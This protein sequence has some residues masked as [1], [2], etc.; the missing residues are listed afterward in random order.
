MSVERLIGG[1]LRVANEDLAGARLLAA[2]NNRNAV[3]LLEQCAEKL[4]RAILTAEG[5]HA[6]ISHRLD[7]MVSLLPDENPLKKRLRS[8]EHLAAYATAFR[9]PSP[10][11][12]I[13]APPSGKD[14][15]TVAATLEA[16]LADA[17]TRFV[18]DLTTADSVAKK[19]GA[20]R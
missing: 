18:V 5:T 2:A 4:I 12:R 17:A 11:G 7:E 19:P 3:Y 10:V 16:L 14:L 13:K 1:L 15:E 20:L 8:V 6:G 9:Y